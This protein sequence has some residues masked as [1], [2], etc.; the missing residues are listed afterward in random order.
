MAVAFPP[1]LSTVAKSTLT[2]PLAP[3]SLVTMIL[4][5]GVDSLTVKAS[6]LNWRLPVWLSPDQVDAA[7][8]S[9]AARQ[10][11]ILMERDSGAPEWF[12]CFRPGNLPRGFVSATKLP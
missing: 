5:R 9:V 2:V 4:A 1:P 8:A 10:S 7:S 11:R 3:P 12:G 6:E